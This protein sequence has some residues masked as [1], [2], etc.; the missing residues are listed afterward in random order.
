M[1]T[2]L[3]RAGSAQK[4]PQLWG[5]GEGARRPER[6]REAH[7]WV[8]SARYCP[9]SWSVLASSRSAPCAGTVL[10][11]VPCYLTCNHH[12]SPPRSRPRQRERRRFTPKTTSA[13]SAEPDFESELV[14]SPRL[15]HSASVPHGPENPTEGLHAVMPPRP[16]R[17]ALNQG[18]KRLR[19]RGAPPVHAGRE[20]NGFK[21]RQW[22]WP[23]EG[24]GVPG[25]QRPLK[26][27]AGG[28]HPAGWAGGLSRNRHFQER[29]AQRPP[30]R[31]S[32]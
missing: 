19:A 17:P 31:R 16:Q 14:Q 6:T 3:P 20:A 24:A 18:T 30:T 12:H 15:N 25:V 22:V 1:C 9:G 28:R 23:P 4:C 11:A 10:S 5:G 2:Q 27:Q 29:K 32:S 21:G 26:E 7:E 8:G 13:E